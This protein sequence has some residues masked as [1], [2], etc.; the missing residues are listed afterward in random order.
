MTNKAFEERINNI[1]M[2]VGG[3]TVRIIN[4]NTNNIYE[5]ASDEQLNRIIELTEKDDWEDIICELVE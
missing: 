3:Y 2:M 4:P 5:V 1:R